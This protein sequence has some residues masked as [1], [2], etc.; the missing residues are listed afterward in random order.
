MLV[1]C[2]VVLAVISY[3]PNFGDIVTLIGNLAWPVVLI[4]VIYLLR[5]EVKSFFR[6]VTRKVEDPKNNL[7][8]GK[9]GLEIKRQ[10]E[11]TQAKVDE[12]KLDQ[13]TTQALAL[14]AFV[15]KKKAGEKSIVSKESI[16]AQLS[17]LA[18]NYMNINASEWRERVR[19]KDAAAREL[20]SFVIVNEVSR[21]L[22]GSQ[23]HEGLILALAAASHTLPESGDLDALMHVAHEVNRLHVKY[24]I[25]LA[26]GRL[27]ERGMVDERQKEEIL[28]VLNLYK[29]DADNSLRRRIEQTELL[30]RE[31]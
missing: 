12:M 16:P 2:L 21:T 17:E 31:G 1:A 30:M 3:H 27:F 9:S 6:A 7:L 11:Q 20:A 14:Q 19:L 23:H 22:L 13:E 8:I 29:H 10:I 18:E 28:Q 26:M 24:R 25:V 15:L 4:F 5:D